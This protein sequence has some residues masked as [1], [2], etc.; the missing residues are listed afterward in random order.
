MQMMIAED[1]P[2]GFLQRISIINAVRTDK[3]EGWVE[4]MGGIS[5]WINPWT[6]LKVHLK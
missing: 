2:Y 4:T 6:Y 1:L 3:F 5:T